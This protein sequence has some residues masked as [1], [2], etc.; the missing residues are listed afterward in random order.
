MSPRR[1]SLVLLSRLAG[2]TASSARSATGMVAPPSTS[3]PASSSS[4][5]PSAS[6]PTPRLGMTSSTS[7]VMRRRRVR[8]RRATSTFASGPTCGCL[9]H[10]L[11]RRPRASSPRFLPTL[12]KWFRAI[13][14][15]HRGLS[16]SIKNGSSTICGNTVKPSLPPT[17]GNLDWGPGVMSLPNGKNDS[18]T[19]AIRRPHLTPVMQGNGDCLNDYQ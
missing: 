6:A 14:H 13:R 11:S 2:A 16:F 18:D 3:S 10:T 7:V 5:L 17:E 8:R 19:S 1:L 9:S 4:S 15:D 12:T